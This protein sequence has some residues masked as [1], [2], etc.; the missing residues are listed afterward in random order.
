MNVRPYGSY[1]HVLSKIFF[2]DKIDLNFVYFL[3]TIYFF[4]PYSII[5]LCKNSLQKVEKSQT[6]RKN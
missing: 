4:N 5:C 1:I 3:V 6:K 2:Y